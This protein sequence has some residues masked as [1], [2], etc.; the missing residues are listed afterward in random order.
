MIAPGTSHS[1]VVTLVL[2]AA[3]KCVPLAQLAHNFAI[4]VDSVDLRP[5]ASPLQTK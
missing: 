5:A 1:A 3:G 4:L 2:R